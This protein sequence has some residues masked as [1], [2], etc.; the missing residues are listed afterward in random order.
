MKI[1]EIVKNL[2]HNAIKY[3]NKGFV[4]CEV[5]V[6]NSFLISVYMTAV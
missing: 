1:Y 3:T 6:N 4:F 2:I 5:N